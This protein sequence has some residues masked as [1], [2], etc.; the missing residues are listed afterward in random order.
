MVKA[1][2]ITVMLK[3]AAVTTV[4]AKVAAITPTKRNNSSGYN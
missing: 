1:A 4:M 2:E 3:R